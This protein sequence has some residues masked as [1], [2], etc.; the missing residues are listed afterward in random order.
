[1]SRKV[2]WR[3]HSAGYPLPSWRRRASYGADR[4]QPRPR[5][6]LRL[7]QHGRLRTEPLDDRADELPYAGRGDENRHFALARG[8][9]E[10]LAHQ[11]DELGQARRLHGEVALLALA[12]DRFGEGLLPAGRQRDQRQ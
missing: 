5:M 6:D 10:T 7:R 1:M 12:D 4:L 8:L 9:L 11:G 2:S 3:K